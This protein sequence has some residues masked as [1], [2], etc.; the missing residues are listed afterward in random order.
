VKFRIDQTGGLSGG[1]L[2]PLLHSVQ[3]QC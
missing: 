2:V 1:L 3:Q